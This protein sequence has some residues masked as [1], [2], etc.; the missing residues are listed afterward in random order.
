MNSASLLCLVRFICRIVKLVRIARSLLVSK[1]SGSNSLQP[2]LRMM[3]ETTL[4]N[5]KAEDW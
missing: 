1:I 5:K 4:K 2:H 3:Y